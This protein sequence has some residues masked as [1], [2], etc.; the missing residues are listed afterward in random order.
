[1]KIQELIQIVD[2]AYPDGKVGEYYAEPEK[3]HGD[4]LA[5]FVY[6]ELIDTFD[7]VATRKKQLATAA[8]AMNN[9]I[10]ELRHVLKEIEGQP[11]EAKS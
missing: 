3:D 7:P 4:T 1:M 2:S 8:R 11:E 10:Y 9:A 5:K 6:L